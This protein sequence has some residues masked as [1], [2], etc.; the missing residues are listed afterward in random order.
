MVL[1]QKLEE[2]MS[3]IGSSSKA[4]NESSTAL[5]KR[6][7]TSGINPD[8]DRPFSKRVRVE[9]TEGTF[10]HLS[11]LDELPNYQPFTGP[12]GNTLLQ[13]L[14][15]IH[16]M[17]KDGNFESDVL[18][19]H[20]NQAALALPEV[21]SC[22][23]SSYQKALD[24]MNATISDEESR[25]ALSSMNVR[26]TESD[27]Q[28]TLR[29]AA[30]IIASLLH[31]VTKLDYSAVNKPC[32][33]VIYSYVQMFSHIFRNI[34]TFAY[35]RAK[36]G[37]HNE[38]LNV[39]N[40]KPKRND[41]NTLINSN[42]QDISRLI[43]QLVLAT[44]SA[45][46]PSHSAHK[47]LYEG[48]TYLVLDAIG[49]RLYLAVFGCEPGKIVEDQILVS[50]TTLNATH[51]GRGLDTRALQYEIPYLVHILER[52]MSLAASFMS[53]DLPTPTR[54][55]QQ[56]RSRSSLNDSKPPGK[57]ER[58][59][60]KVTLTTHA[61]RRLQQTLVRGMFGEE[62]NDGFFDSLRIPSPLS[63]IAKPPAF[64]AGEMRE[65]FK[66]EVWKMLGWEILGEVKDC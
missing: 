34:H 54:K 35:A 9:S 1:E 20:L 55:S 32:G 46:S 59:R 43:S 37:F 61:K 33:S 10:T 21:I 30:R 31:G 64:D 48:F 3:K 19:W 47:D 39:L 49:K 14:Y 38:D 41:A 8:V 25:S 65:W 2:E 50:N 16:K 15:V 28:S 18:G 7:K 6:K 11:G 42:I 53:R 27:M 66:C 13:S 57:A 23:C 22:A 60:A 63:Q 5:G 51:A 56:K 62:P 26:T 40:K 24:E 4:R 36:G 45:L 52:C 58:Y 44:L 17:F 12:Q 29:S